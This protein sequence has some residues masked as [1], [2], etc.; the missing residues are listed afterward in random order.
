MPYLLQSNI[1]FTCKYGLFDLEENYIKGNLNQ[2]SL[3]DVKK[4]LDNPK[5][6]KNG[7]IL[8]LLYCS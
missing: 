5:N 8:L 1:P 3:E 4:F 6:S 2:E 7:F